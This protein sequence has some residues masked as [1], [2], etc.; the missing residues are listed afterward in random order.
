MVCRLSAVVRIF[1]LFIHE[2]VGNLSKYS[3]SFPDAANQYFGNVGECFIFYMI[4]FWGARSSSV[5]IVEDCVVT[6]IYLVC[7]RVAELS[8]TFCTSKFPICKYG[9]QAFICSSYFQ[10]IY[11]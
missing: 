5:L 10:L 7:S 4:C 6:S 9:L 2:R 11:T 8:N 3:S 1:S